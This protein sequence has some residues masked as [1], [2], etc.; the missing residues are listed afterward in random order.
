MEAG[1]QVLIYSG[2]LDII[3]AN[4]LTDNFVKSLEWSGKDDFAA[5]PREKW[6]VPDL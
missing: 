1:Y 5:A 6:F 3:I 4:T 2:Q